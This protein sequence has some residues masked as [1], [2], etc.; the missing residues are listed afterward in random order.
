MSN[1]ASPRGLGDLLRTAQPQAAATIAVDASDLF[2]E[3]V[4][5]VYAEPSPAQ[6]WAALEQAR[7]LRRRHPEWTEE[8]CRMVAYVAQAHR[9]PEVAITDNVV[10]LYEK[11]VQEQPRLWERA[12]GAITGAFATAGNVEEAAKE[13]EGE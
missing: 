8:F 3:P 9:E 12:F 7:A 13:R 1:R 4:A 5:F 10:L 11:L 6:L 2:D